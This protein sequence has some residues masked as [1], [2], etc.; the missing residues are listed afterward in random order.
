MRIKFYFELNV[1]TRLTKDTKSI[2]KR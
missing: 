2:A 1:E